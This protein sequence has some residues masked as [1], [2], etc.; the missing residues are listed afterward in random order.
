MPNSPQILVVD[1][2]QSL[3]RATMRL[4]TRAGYRVFEAATGNEALRLAETHRP[5]LILLDVMLPDINGLDVCRRI[6]TNPAL[7]DTYV[8][9]ISG[10]KNTTDD[11]VTGLNAGA[12]GYI[13]R[14]VSNQEL[15]A[16]VQATLRFQQAEVGI[17]E[18]ETRYQQ[19]FKNMPSGV[20]VYEAINDGADFVLK[21]FNRVAEQ[22]EDIERNDI[23]GRR[24]TEVFP[25]VKTFGLFEV[26]QRVWQTGK[27]EFFPAGHYQD[28]RITGWRE[29]Y[30]YRLPSGEI[31]AIYNDVTERKQA[32]EAL[33]ESEA[34][35]KTLFEILPVGISIVD[36][37]RNVVEVNPALGRIVQ[38]SKEDLLHGKHTG[39]HYLQRD[40]TVMPVEEF[41][42]VRAIKEQQAAENIEIG[43][44]KE[45]GETIWTNVSAVPVAFSDWR[46]VITTIDITDRIQ[47]EQRRQEQMERELTA[48]AVLSAPS[49]TVSA[50]SFG[51]VPLRQNL[52]D[53]FD[54]LVTQ[55]GKIIALSLEQRVYKVDHPISDRL[56]AIAH[57]LGLLRAGPR[58]II[59]M[60]STAIKLQ[61]ADDNPAKARAYAEE[62]HLIVLELMGYLTS[63][64]RNYALGAHED[65]VPQETGKGT[66]KNG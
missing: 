33:R 59:E 50:Q 53:I 58:D 62:S 65:A 66:K 44:V 56:R 27:T 3:L 57:R 36:N 8:M 14:P 4:L 41:P 52:P 20:A 24:I 38:L 26:L 16:R 9:L 51:L 18:S 13:G 61:A 30:V 43:V 28:E 15:L 17:K 45:D 6:K 7:V 32:E 31:V 49:S 39:R 12:D 42:S 23:I 21:D 34:K 54:E 25:G 35:L 11:Q 64:Y 60:H 63:Y 46:V 29:N 55:Y 47:E 5:N 19:L 22:V 40:G 37:E 48:L 1:D 10:L 2:D